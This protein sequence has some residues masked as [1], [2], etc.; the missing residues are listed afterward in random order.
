MRKALIPSQDPSYAKEK[1]TECR[2]SNEVVYTGISIN[3]GKL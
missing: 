3:L 2:K 1:R